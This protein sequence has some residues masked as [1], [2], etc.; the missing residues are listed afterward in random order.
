MRAFSVSVRMRRLPMNSM[1]SM[2][3]CCWP[4]GCCCAGAEDGAWSS[5]AS[6]PV[7]KS[8]EAENKILPDEKS[9][10]G[11]SSPIA[12]DALANREA[13]ATTRATR[14]ANP[15][16]GKQTLLGA[17]H[18]PIKAA[19]PN[20]RCSSPAEPGVGRLCDVSDSLVDDRG[21]LADRTERQAFACNINLEGRR[22]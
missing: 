15:P 18:G 3:D 20:T 21:C 16:D 12:A 7:I 1:R 9:A 19:P 22:P 6:L 10:V 2:I 17:A 14:A 8:K 4:E 13:S 5:M 11:L